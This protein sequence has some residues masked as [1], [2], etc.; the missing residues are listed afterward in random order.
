[1]RPV[2]VV[3]STPDIEAG[4]DLV[5]VA[6][7]TARIDPTSELQVALPWDGQGRARTG[8][9]R[10][11]AAVCDWLVRFAKEDAEFVSGH[12]RTSILAE[13]L[14]RIPRV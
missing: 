14:R 2:V 6:V 11:S 5:G 3:T 13:I 10:E 7:T 1:M 12:L 8:L 4:A 9:T